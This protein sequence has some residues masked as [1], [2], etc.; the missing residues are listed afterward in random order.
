MDTTPHR[1]APPRA[2]I[3]RNTLERPAASLDAEALIALDWAAHH[4]EVRHRL[5]PQPAVIIRRALEVYRHHLEALEAS[6]DETGPL[7]RAGKGNPSALALT[8]ARARLEA[9][10]GRP[11]TWLETRYSPED[12]AMTA[13]VDTKVSQLFETLGVASQ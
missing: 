3:G 2:L 5:R 8:Q 7:M 4:I 13:A 6:Q 11:L 12:R 10:Q 9:S 1:V